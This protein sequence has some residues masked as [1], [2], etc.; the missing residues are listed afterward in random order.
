MENEQKLNFCLSSLEAA[1]KNTR[2]YFDGKALKTGMVNWKSRAFVKKKN[3]LLSLSRSLRVAAVEKHMHYLRQLIL[4]CDDALK[5][6][7]TEHVI[8]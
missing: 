2:N 4:V 3:L 5:V 7:S 1:K 8:L 6:G